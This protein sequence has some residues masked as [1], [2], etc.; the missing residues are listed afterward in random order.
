MRITVEKEM[1]MIFTNKEGEKDYHYFY[2]DFDVRGVYGDQ[3]FTH[4]FGTTQEWG[5]DD[6]EI[7]WDEEQYTPE[8]NKYINEYL[9]NNI[10][11]FVDDLEKARKNY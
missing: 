7:Q 10:N 5:W 1:E 11:E 8:E 9:D 3:G 6:V 4:E 2:V